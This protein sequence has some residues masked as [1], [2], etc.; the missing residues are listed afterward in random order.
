MILNAVDD[1]LFRELI[2]GKLLELICY[3]FFILQFVG[4]IIAFI[5]NIYHSDSMNLHLSTPISIDRLY[6]SKFAETFYETT[7]MFTV[8]TLPIGIAYIQVLELPISFLFI[9][10]VA[11]I[12]FLIIPNSL[13]FIVATIITYF[14]SIIWRRGFI[15]IIAIAM[16]SIWLLAKLIS[17]LNEVKLE[18][19]GGNAIVDLIGLFD[20][21]NPTWLPSNW[22][23]GILTSYIYQGSYPTAL[24]LLLLWIGAL[25]AFAASYLVFDFF[26]LSV[27]SR[28]FSHDGGRFSGSSLAQSDLTRRIIERVYLSLPLEQAMRAIMLKDMT[29]L[30]RDKSQSLKLVMYL[31]IAA[32]Y[33][34]LLKFMSSAQNLNIYGMS[35]WW[36]FLGGINALFGGF[37]LTALMTRLVYP[38]ISLEGKAFWIMNS[39]PIALKDLLKAKFICWLPL[40]M[41]ISISLLLAGILIIAPSP[42]AIFSTIIIAIFL[43]FGCTALAIG[44]GA[45]FAKFEWESANQISS[46]LGTLV[47]F[48]CSLVFVV[49]V[50]LCSTSAYLAIIPPWSWSKYWQYLLAT[51]ASSFIVVA[52]CTSI[53]SRKSLSKGAKSLAEKRQ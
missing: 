1:E 15:L 13:G 20:N 40:S 28:S 14:T 11:I 16:V 25:G 34:I 18:H 19:G 47:L 30:F 3:A 41:T 27:R 35:A 53:L 24:S 44:T 26:M 5:G 51:I 7:F 42:A 32:S 23:A 21:P 33:L 6:C 17:I 36:A 12:P 43:S 48:F 45:V 10:I 31:G 2:P 8:F 22:L 46:G 52:L 4:A 38:S 9:G 37:I 39:A 50:S 29:T 49:I